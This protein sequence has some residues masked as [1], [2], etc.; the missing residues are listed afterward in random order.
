MAR[1]CVNLG[2]VYLIRGENNAALHSMR[3]ALNLAER[4]GDLPNMAFVMV[5]LGGV[6]HRSGNLQEAEH[7]LK[8]GLALCEQVNDR[9]RL[10]W[11]HADLAAVQIDQGY[12]QEARENIL[13]AITIGRAIKISRCIH[14]ALVILGDLRI[15]EVIHSSPLHFDAHAMSHLYVP[16]N[17]PLLSRAKQTLQH[18]LALVGMEIEATIEGQLSLATVYF[19]LGELASA[20][21]LAYQALQEAQE[22]EII[23][24][25]GRTYRLLGLILAAQADH[26]QAQYCFEQAMQIFRERELRLDYARTLYYYSFALIK[27]WS[28]LS[29]RADLSHAWK[30]AG[31]HKPVPASLDATRTQNR[32]RQGDRQDP[33]Q[34]RQRCLAYLQE[35]HT[36]FTASQATNDLALI[37]DALTAIEVTLDQQQSTVSF[38]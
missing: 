34:Y 14:H 9:E 3:R 35:A 38:M 33:E 2:G 12:F 30:A 25:V 20:C 21:D 4:T 15:A 22:Q 37:R 27:C 11:C 1:I 26:A 24:T 13:R 28:N 31:Y 23:R 32:L 36:I 5:N 8:Q 16:L 19:L 10:S 7:C 6:A 18:A 17:S 29:A